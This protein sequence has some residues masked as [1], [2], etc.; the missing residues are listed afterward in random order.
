MV[1]YIYNSKDR[2]PD[3][4]KIIK[5]LEWP[6][7]NNI[8]TARAFIGVYIYFRIWIEYFALIAIPIYILFKKKNRVSIGIVINRCNNIAII[9]LSLIRRVEI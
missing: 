8:T 3:V 2:H 5:I 9:R 1:E 6:P 4:F 7:L